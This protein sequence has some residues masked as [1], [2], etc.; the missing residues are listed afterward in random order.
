MPNCRLSDHWQQTSLIEV[1]FENLRHTRM[2]LQEWTL[3]HNPDMSFVRDS[4]LL[5]QSA[6]E[7]ISPPPNK[8]KLKP[9]LH[10]LL[11]HFFFS[12]SE[13]IFQSVFVGSGWMGSSSLGCV[14]GLKDG[15]L[16]Q[17][18]K[19]SVAKRC[20]GW[21]PCGTAPRCCRQWES[22]ADTRR[23]GGYTRETRWD[24]YCLAK[25]DKLRE[26]PWYSAVL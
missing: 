11:K 21:A 20:D 5:Y 1:L 4:V 9:N 3:T 7:Y 26:S 16:S 8:K 2:D 14:R 23:E 10:I 25:E 18:M 12:S 19:W 22:L 15:F 17:K 13:A 24:H 6:C